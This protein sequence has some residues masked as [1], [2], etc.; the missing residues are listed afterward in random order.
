MKSDIEIQRD[1]MDELLWEPSIH[2]SDIGVV[3]RNGV[4]TLMG[5]VRNYGEKLAAEKAAKRIKEVKAVIMDINI[6]ICNKHMKAD[7]E[8]TEAALNALKWNSFVPEDR[9]QLKVENAWITLEGEVEWQFQK[10][11]ATNAVHHLVG[12]RGVSNFIKVKPVLTPILVKDVIK[13]AL[14]RSADIEAEKIDIELS[15]G[16]IILKGKVRSWGERRA[17]ERAVWATPGVVDVNDELI[18]SSK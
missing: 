5:A 8:I 9:I 6:R 10:E 16:K 14:E 12:V 18:I 11:S 7:K 4:V 13:K 3:V 1:V 15:G 17:V 2:A